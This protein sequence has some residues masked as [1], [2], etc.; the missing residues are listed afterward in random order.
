MRRHAVSPASLAHPDIGEQLPA[1]SRLQ[2]YGPHTM[3]IP[4]L[5]LALKKRIAEFSAHGY[6]SIDFRR[7]QLID[8]LDFVIR[9]GV[10]DLNKSSLL[11]PLYIGHI[12]SFQ[13]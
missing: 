11:K 3:G 9:Q 5:H 2:H 13:R 4:V 12:R 1:N 8:A 10:M 6:E 7:A